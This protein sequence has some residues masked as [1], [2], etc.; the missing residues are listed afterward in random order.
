MHTKCYLPCCLLCTATKSDHLLFYLP[1]CFPIPPAP[2]A[3]SIWLTYDCI[4]IFELYIDFL[5]Y[6]CVFLAAETLKKV[7]TLQNFCPCIVFSLLLPTPTGPCYPTQIYLYLH[8]K[9]SNQLSVLF[10]AL[11]GCQNT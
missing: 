4:L 8:V 5:C 6:F 9:G 3:A 2:T 1:P 11:S 10:L 7:K